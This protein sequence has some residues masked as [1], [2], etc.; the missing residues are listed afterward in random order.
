[1]AKGRLIVGQ[2]SVREATPVYSGSTT[3]AIHQS[4]SGL[5]SKVS[6]GFFNGDFTPG[7][8]RQVADLEG[9]E[10]NAA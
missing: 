10:L 9:P 6:L 3:R 7:T 2:K 4:E 1:M 5:G 8:G